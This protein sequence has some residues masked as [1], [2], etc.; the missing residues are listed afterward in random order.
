MLVCSLF[1][2]KNSKV[3]LIGPNMPS[4]YSS[5]GVI[6]NMTSINILYEFT[7]TIINWACKF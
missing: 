6:K 7:N 1:S 3:H 5:Y 2:A 4:S